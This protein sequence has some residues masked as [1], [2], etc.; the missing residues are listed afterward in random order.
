MKKILFLVLGFSF[1]LCVTGKENIIGND[2]IINDT[3]EGEVYWVPHNVHCEYLIIET[4]YYFVLCKKEWGT[5]FEVHD[6]V[7]GELHQYN[8]HE[9]LNLTRKSK[10]TVWIE[11]YESNKSTCFTW[12]N[13]HTNCLD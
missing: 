12:V 1:L 6:K 5:N 2:K 13:R 4:S 8:R 11:T 3:V 9:I 10:G 7:K